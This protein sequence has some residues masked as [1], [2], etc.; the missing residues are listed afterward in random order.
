[1]KW[2]HTINREVDIKKINPTADAFN[3]TNLFILY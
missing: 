1:M 2:R 3:S